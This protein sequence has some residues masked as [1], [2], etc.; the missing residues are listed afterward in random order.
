MKNIN[1]DE[2]KIDNTE[3]DEIYTELDFEVNEFNKELSSLELVEDLTEKVIK[4][5]ESEVRGSYEYKKYIGYLKDELDLNSCPLMPQIKGD[6]NMASIEFHHYPLNLYEISEIIATQMILSLGEDEKVSCFEIAER[7]MREHYL[8]TIGLI[9]LTKTLHKMAHNKS[10]IVPISKVNGNYKLFLAKY[11]SYIPQDIYDRIVEAE[12]NSESDEA[13]A[14]NEAKL[15][16]NIVKYNIT[17][18][19]AGGI[20]EF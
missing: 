8:G 14:Y 9:P 11:K 4:Y 5:I 19:S 10:I 17:Y 12:L 20:D 3:N 13:Q 1:I 7:V 6:E 16:K 18:N 15:K 2:L